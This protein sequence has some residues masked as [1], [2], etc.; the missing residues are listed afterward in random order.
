MGKW[1]CGHPN[2]ANSLSKKGAEPIREAPPTRDVDGCRSARE[3]RSEGARCRWKDGT[4]SAL[5]ERGG[6]GRDDVWLQTTGP[7]FVNLAH[8]GSLRSKMGETLGG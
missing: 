5:P 3:G 1:F 6:E 2:E 7:G 4:E 8:G